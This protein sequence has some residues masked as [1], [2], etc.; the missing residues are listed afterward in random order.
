MLLRRHELLREYIFYLIR[1]QLS[2]P[3]LAWCIVYFG[4]LGS[5]WSTVLANLIGGLLFFWVDKFLIFR[6]K[7]TTEIWEV[8]HDKECYR[9]NKIGRVYRLVKKDKYDK[10][11]S[12]PVYLCEQCSDKKYR[13][14]LESEFSNG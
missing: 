9:C 7:T 12:T 13:K 1:W 2:T 14:I 4:S 11:V 3:I 5:G 6:N 8:L 10:T